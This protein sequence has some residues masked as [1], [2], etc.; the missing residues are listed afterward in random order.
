MKGSDDM[1]NYLREFWYEEDGAEF[2]ET[3]I[4]LFF[5]AG[6]IAVMAYVFTQAGNKIGESGDTISAMDTNSHVNTNP[7]NNTP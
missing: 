4:V 5:V 3:A 2:V 7:Y 1:K 6:L